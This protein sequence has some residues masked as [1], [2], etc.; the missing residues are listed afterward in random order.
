[1]TTS[2]GQSPRGS[3]QKFRPPLSTLPKNFRMFET[4]A[5]VG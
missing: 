3:Q 2:R 4:F 1:L 5:F